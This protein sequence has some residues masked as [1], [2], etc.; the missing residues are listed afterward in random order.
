MSWARL[1]TAC[2]CSFCD[3]TIAAGDP[4]R[5]SSVEAMRRIRWCASCAKKRLDEG[6]PAD[7]PD[8]V[9]TTVTGVQ[10]MHQAPATRTK[11]SAK[12]EPFNR[13]DTGAQ[14]R[15]NIL[16]WR[17]DGRMEATGEQGR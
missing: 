11:P 16:N 8:A 1:A 9:A 6:V 10:R 4:V 14:L 5:R 7:L 17:R 15:A 3:R 13:K 2:T 12:F